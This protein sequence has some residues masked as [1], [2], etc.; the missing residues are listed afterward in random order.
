VATSFTLESPAF[1]AGGTI[2]KRF[3]CDGEN[4]SPE[5]RWQGA[6]DGTRSF[7]LLVEDP[8]ARKG[9]FTDWILFDIPAS[10][11]NLPEGTKA[12]EVGIAGTNDSRKTGYTGPCP[13]P[14][15]GAHLACAAF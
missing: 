8:D 6:P 1:S 14:G 4:V 13:P 7:A 2:P 5:L 9:T 15:H 10:R 11:S 3:T 12:G